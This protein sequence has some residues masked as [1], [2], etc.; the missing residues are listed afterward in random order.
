MDGTEL[1][2]TLLNSN[3]AEITIMKVLEPE[4]NERAFYRILKRN[5]TFKN[6]YE[7]WDYM[8]QG[9]FEDELDWIE[10]EIKYDAFKKGFNTALEIMGLE[11]LFE[12]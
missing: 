7:K 1:I 9:N 4:K 3:T 10:D 8:T 2:K 11:P 6:S 12:I 5:S